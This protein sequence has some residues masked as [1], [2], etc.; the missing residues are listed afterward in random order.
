MKH[1]ILVSH[2][3]FAFG[4]RDAVEVVMGE[5]DNITPVGLEKEMSSNEFRKKFQ[6]VIDSFGEDD[7]IILLC[8]IIGGSPFTSSLELLQEKGFYEK[9]LV[10]TGMNMP[11]LVQII[12]EQEE[13]SLQE[14]Q[15][16][17]KEIKSDTI[18]IFEDRQEEEDD[19]EL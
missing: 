19:A 5:Q 9:S 15:Q 8:D 17:I 13:K 16:E 7:E 6:S 12:L 4:L 2:G 11:L 10:V 1:I 14:L 18:Q 3:L